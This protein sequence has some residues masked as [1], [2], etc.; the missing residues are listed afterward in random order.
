MFTRAE[1]HELYNLAHEIFGS[2]ADYAAHIAKERANPTPGA[3]APEFANAL[4]SGRKHMLCL[5]HLTHLIFNC[6]DFA[7]ALAYIKSKKDKRGK[8]VLSIPNG[9]V[10]L[11][12]TLDRAGLITIDKNQDPFGT[13]ELFTFLETF[14]KEML[15]LSAETQEAFAKAFVAILTPFLRVRPAFGLSSPRRRKPRRQRHLEAR[16]IAA[17]VQPGFRRNPASIAERRYRTD[18]RRTAI[19]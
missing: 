11:A 6:K 18:Q 5:G 19:G 2:F 12:L 7:G 10:S 17:I 14:A 13:G 9:A 1:R 15:S 8:V 3:V 4:W 16:F